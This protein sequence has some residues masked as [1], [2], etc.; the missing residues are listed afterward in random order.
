MH[1][2]V[3]E[4]RRFYAEEIAAV[5]AIRSP[6]LIEAFAK[7][8]REHFLGPGPWQLGSPDFGMQAPG[9]RYRPTEDSDPRRLYHNVLVSIDP[10]RNL[11]N[12][13]PSTLAA[14]LDALD[15]ATGERLFHLGCGLGYYA[16]V[17]AEVVG[18]N[19]HVTTMEVDP[20]LARRS[21]ENLAPWK[22]VEVLA[23]DG[24]LYD[25]GPVDVIFVN[26]GVTQ[27]RPIWLD[28]LLPGGRLLVP[29]T[30]ETGG[31]AGKGGMLLVKHEGDSYAA[32]FITFVMIY[33]CTSLRDLQLNGAIM[34]LLSS[35]K[36]FSVHSLRRDPHEASDTCLLHGSDFCLVG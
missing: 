10:E 6:S 9:L 11:N 4:Q 14:W 30:F 22:N 24:G 8:P 15:I 28:R 16:A 36:M 12:G 19:G 31:Q 5:A 35:G 23:G 2:T 13:H 34:K 26:A 27:V 32:Q 3:E 7:V 1:V 21:H 17:M 29:L 18:P 20:N 25:P 33:S